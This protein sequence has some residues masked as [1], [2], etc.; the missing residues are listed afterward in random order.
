MHNKKKLSVDQRKKRNLKNKTR[1]KV[2]YEKGEGYVN[3]MMSENESFQMEE[4]KGKTTKENESDESN[5][6]M[7]CCSSSNT[8]NTS[9]NGD[10]F[11]PAGKSSESVLKS[12]VEPQYENYSSTEGDKGENGF[13]MAEHTKREAYS[14]PDPKRDSSESGGSSDINSSEISEAGTEDSL[15]ES[16]SKLKGNI[17]VIN[18]F[19]L[20]NIQI[21]NNN[22][23]TKQSNQD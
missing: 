10:D 1:T 2:K 23:H 3:M 14:G 15:S 11:Q 6:Y 21:G 20:K 17:Q 22:V 13:N 7:N 9:V 19:N 5:V 8:T 18:I 12:G 16:E 4:E